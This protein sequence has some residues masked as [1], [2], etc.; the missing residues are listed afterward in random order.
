[1]PTNEQHYDK[2]ETRT[3]E[4][5]ESAHFKALPKQIANAQ[6]RSSAF[7]DILAKVDA[8]SIGDRKALAALPVTYKSELIAMQRKSPPFGGLSATPIRELGRVFASP[9]PI[10]EPEG[11]RNDYWRLARALFAAGIRRGE[12]IHNTFAYHMTPAGFMLESGAHALGCPVVPAGTGQT[13]LQVET[14]ENLRPPSYVGTP[15][16]LKI[17]LDRAAEMERDVSSLKRALVSGEALPPTL[18]QEIASSGIDVLQ[19]YATADLGLIAYESQ[20]Q[21]GMI[22]DEGIIV[23]IVTPGTGNPV[24]AGEVGEIVVTT[25]NP[26][27]PLI[28]FATGDLSASLDGDSPCGRTAPRIRGWMGRADQTT[29]V[30]GMFVHPSQVAT[31]TGRYEDLVKTRLVVDRDGVNDVM[32]LRCEAVSGGSK[33]L[34]GKI[35]DSLRDVCKVRGE[36][37]FVEVGSLP[38]DGKVIDDV[39]PIE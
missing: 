32:T 28:R 8:E 13:E 37:E 22:I 10:Y 25:F 5:R 24:E 29:K 17:I 27:Y 36:V 35:E 11:K 3:H 31:V 38:K 4:E 19:C 33:S 9:G 39:R 12:L 30:R 23:E 2:L 14:I 18:R 20:A 21:E 7:A 1:M 26:D 34:A 16:F 6:Q 15:S